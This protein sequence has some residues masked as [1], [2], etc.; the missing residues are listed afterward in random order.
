MNPLSQHS[1]K[2]RTPT[3]HRTR[4]LLTTGLLILGLLAPGLLQLSA[5]PEAEKILGTWTVSDG[6]MKIE[7]VKCQGDRFCGRIAWMKDPNTPAGQP[8]VDALNP[9]PK[10]RSVSLLGMEVLWGLRFENGKWV[11]GQIYDIADGKTYKCAIQQ[12]DPAKLQVQSFVGIAALGKTR[13]WTR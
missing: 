12:S 5:A 13:T 4:R 6:S 2:L 8:R 1:S 10:K 9:N 7:I 11:K 3:R